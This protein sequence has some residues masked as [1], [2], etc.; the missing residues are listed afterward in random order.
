MDSI[1]KSHHPISSD[2]HFHQLINR[3]SFDI[4][5]NSTECPILTDYRAG[6][7]ISI[8]IYYIYLYLSIYIYIHIYIY[9]Y[10]YLYLHL[11][12]S[13]HFALNTSSHSL[14][15]IISLFI[16]LAIKKYLNARESVV[17]DDNRPIFVSEYGG[18]CKD[19][20]KACLNVFQSRENFE[21]TAYFIYKAIPGNFTPSSFLSFL[22]VIV[23]AM[24]YLLII[25]PLHHRYYYSYSTVRNKPHSVLYTLVVNDEWWNLMDR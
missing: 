3:S 25:F 22:I 7:Y 9:I 24:K 11:S 21:P 16:P 13:S 20:L 23:I 6:K 8:F 10:I 2:I 17:E 18:E 12:I 5:Y 14:F 1:S 15:W 19:W 4:I